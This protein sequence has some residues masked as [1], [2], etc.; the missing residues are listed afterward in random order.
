MAE[1]ICE[2]VGI[3]RSF[4]RASLGAS[5][6]AISRAGTKDEKVGALQAHLGTAGG[7]RGVDTGLEKE[8]ALKGGVPNGGYSFAGRRRFGAEGVWVDVEGG[9]Q[10][11]SKGSFSIRDEKKGKMPRTALRYA[12]E[13]MPK[14]WKKEAMRKDWQKE[15]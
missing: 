6:F 10:P 7:G 8:I 13:K 4:V 2:G 11:V 5:N 9:E 14:R 1:K 12:I 15:N 3:V